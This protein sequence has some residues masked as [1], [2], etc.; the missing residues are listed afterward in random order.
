MKSFMLLQKITKI[1]KSAEFV[2]PFGYNKPKRF[3]NGRDIESPSK[4]GGGSG[5]SIK[6]RLSAMFQ[7]VF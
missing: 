4:L 7:I 3:I 1:E 2:T 5:M 6:T